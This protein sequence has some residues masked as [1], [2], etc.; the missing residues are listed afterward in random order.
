MPT[1]DHMTKAV[2]PSLDSG[3]LITEEVSHFSEVTAEVHDSFS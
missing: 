1:A 2:E 3:R